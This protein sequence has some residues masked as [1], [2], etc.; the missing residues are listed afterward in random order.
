MGTRVPKYR[1]V[2]P[3][4]L[5]VRPQFDICPR[6]LATSRT[7]GSVSVRATTDQERDVWLQ[8]SSSLGTV[9]QMLRNC[10][11]VPWFCRRIGASWSFS[12]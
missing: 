9:N 1:R 11:G 10:T 5:A 2:A 8:R 4:T 3:R 12:T 7:S 6:E